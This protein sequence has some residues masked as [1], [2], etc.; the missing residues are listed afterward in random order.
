[1]FP[2]IEQSG[3]DKIIE[4]EKR[5]VVNGLRKRG[6][7]GKWMWLHWGPCG[8]E[9]VLHLDSVRV[10]ILVLIQYYVL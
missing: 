5:L 4:M 7:R 10:S 6:A 2:F 1:M 9:I 8:D 3:N